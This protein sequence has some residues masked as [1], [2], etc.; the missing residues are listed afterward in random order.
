MGK[1]NKY[2]SLIL[3]IDI[4]Y[5]SLKN[6]LVKGITFVLN[7]SEIFVLDIILVFCNVSRLV[8]LVV[9]V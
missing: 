7:Y 6:N 1:I 8:F 4:G 5:S 3:C 9:V 2:S